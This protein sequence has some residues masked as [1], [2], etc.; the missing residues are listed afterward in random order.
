ML[1]QIQVKK[2]KEHSKEAVESLP[3]DH[4]WIHYLGS[5]DILCATTLALSENLQQKDSKEN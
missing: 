5:L 2:I 4:P 1:T 3:K